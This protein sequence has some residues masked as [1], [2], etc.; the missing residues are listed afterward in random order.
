MRCVQRGAPSIVFTYSLGEKPGKQERSTVMGQVDLTAE[1]RPL[2]DDVFAQVEGL[3]YPFDPANACC[4]APCPGGA[5][6]NTKCCDRRTEF[7][8]QKWTCVW[9]ATKLKCYNPDETSTDCAWTKVWR[10]N[11]NRIERCDVLKGVCRRKPPRC[12][13]PDDCYSGESECFVPEDAYFAK[14][15][16]IEYVECTKKEVYHDEDRPCHT[17]DAPGPYSEHAMTNDAGGGP[18]PAGCACCGLA[19]TCAPRWVRIHCKEQIPP[20]L[21]YE[22][23]LPYYERPAARSA[24]KGQAGA[25]AGSLCRVGSSANK[26]PNFWLSPARIYA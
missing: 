11:W 24:C 16:E 5:F 17:Y 22:V 15:F 6:C 8:V 21:P 14:V 13:L 19:E 1:I 7:Y 10:C 18:N 3:N 4:Q 12:P 23:P 2:P 9:Q 20:E 26:S 25:C